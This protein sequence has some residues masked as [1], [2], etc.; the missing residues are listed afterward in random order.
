MYFPRKSRLIT[1][2]CKNL[3]SLPIDEMSAILPERTIR[4]IVRVTSLNDIEIMNG[5]VR[6][7]YAD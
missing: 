6:I 1:V 4:E 3:K 5:G 2:I 7:S